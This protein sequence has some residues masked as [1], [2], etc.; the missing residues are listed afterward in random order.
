MLTIINRLIW[1]YR[2]FIRKYIVMDMDLKIEDK[3]KNE[4]KYLW[5]LDPGHGGMIDGEY[6]TAGKRSPKFKDGTVLY[7]GEFNRAVV[8]RI[9]SACNAAG[10]DSIVLV[11]EEEDISLKERVK[12]ANDFYKVDKRAVYLSVHANAFGNN[13]NQAHGWSCYTS[14]GETRSDQIATIFYRMMAAEFPE[15]K[16]RKDHTDKDPDKEADFYVLKKTAMPA[17]LTE[18]FFMTNSKEAAMLLNEDIRDRIADAH[19]DAI[20]YLSK[21]S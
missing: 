21:K 18:N 5:L 9:D 1:H 10:I 14:R 3:S 17:V 19:M 12:R 15:E 2:T 11:P 8:Q 20:Y 6:Q 7:E 13:W 16:M 4:S